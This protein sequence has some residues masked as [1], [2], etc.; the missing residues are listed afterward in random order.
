[1]D[2]RKPHLSLI[3]WQVPEVQKCLFDDGFA[4]LNC[5]FL[6]KFAI[7]SKLRRHDTLKS[8]DIRLSEN[9][10]SKRKNAFILALKKPIERKK[11]IDRTLP[12]CRKHF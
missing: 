9:C 1:M 11:S 3:I 2:C 10:L 7:L 8:S 12:L 4:T 5:P 6:P